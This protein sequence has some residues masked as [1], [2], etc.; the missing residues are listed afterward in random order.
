MTKHQNFLKFG[1]ATPA[2]LPCDVAP[3]KW[4]AAGRFPGALRLWRRVVGIPIILIIAMLMAGSARAQTALANGAS[5]A[6]TLI[7]NTTIAYTFA[8]NAGDNIVL[9]L[10][11]SG[12]SGR[13]DLDGP[14]GALVKSAGGNST[15][16]P[17]AY[18]ATNT[19][20][21]TVRVS[22]FYAGGSGTY[23]LHLAQFPETF[24]VPS[25][26]EGGP[27]TNGGNYSA[28]L[29]LGD[30]DM[31]T[32]TANAGDN[33]VLRLGSS[34][35][36]GNLNLYGPNGALLKTA[37]GNSPDWELPYTAT[38]SGTFTALVSSFYQGN[39]GT[40]DLHLAQFP[41][42]FIVPAGEE[43]GPMTNGGNFGGTLTLG[44][45]NM[46]SFTANAGDNIVLRLG[47]S[48][49]QGNLNLYGPNGALLKTAGGNSPDWEL[50]YTATNSGT[51]TALVSS[52]YQGNTGTYVLHLAQFPEAFTVPA[53]EE[54]G[55]MANGGNYSGTL[56]LGDLDLW[57]FTAN[58][59]DN[60]V[61][62]LGS[63]GFQGN[64]RL[65]GPTGA[66]LKTSGGNSPD[67]ELAYTA[68]NS[69]TFTA[70]VSSFY[71]DNTGT[72][73]LHLAQFP[74]AF[75]VPA[76]DEGGPMANGGNYSGT[77]SLGDLDQWSFTA[78]AGD[79][80]VLRLGS[81][82]FQ[83]NLRLYGPTGA[84]LK[85]SGG[86]SP[87]WE[88]AYTATNSGT[89]TALVSSFYLDNTG[90]YVLHLAQ[91]PEAFTVPAG[92]EGGPMTNG[93]NYSGTLSLGDLDQWSFT[94]CTGDLISLRLN[95]TNF[96]GNLDLYGPT[97]ALLK[98]AGG[99]A[100]TW[101]I[102]YTTTNCGR[103]AVLVSS[104]YGGNSGTYGL[105]A[106]GLSDELRLCAPAISGARLTVN[107]I[108][109]DPGATFILSSTTNVA[110]PFSLWTPVLTNQFD[111]YGV[112]TYTN[113]YNPALTQQYFRFLVP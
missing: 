17:L 16:W 19:G 1:K 53:G 47:S 71:L 43:G 33:I 35:F 78:N 45:Q 104:Y 100:T 37:G 56:S 59:G 113:V 27:M 5:Q 10:G 105:I 21:F 51:F 36:Q 49:F 102:T 6:G 106:N 107:G 34:G 80:I 90:T 74:E 50:P 101:S 29:S 2:K 86:N 42:A 41:E 112:L 4:R 88:L 95:S 77:L 26:D 76:G 32:F 85:T 73:V 31:W 44:D 63:S 97:G 48:G 58:A 94:A 12:F 25:G 82:G 92:D 83:G 8:A 14:T 68:T 81:T 65:Y 40:Y 54:G 13:L 110:K 84:L 52:F 70:L 22:S 9:R 89:F 93:L 62:R 46:W 108:G 15:D 72:Y 39:T 64:L 91:F 55:P 23:V 30:L 38:N 11:S 60:I 7:L 98:S 109:G 66:L 96:E 18:T 20:V 99:N 79:N 57:S 103:F 24:T 75:T 87:D 69:G 67:W 3:N 61:L 28:T 111:Q